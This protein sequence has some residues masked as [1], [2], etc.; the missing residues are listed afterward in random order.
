MWPKNSLS[1]CL[2]PCAQPRLGCPRTYFSGL[3][4]SV[5]R[6]SLLAYLSFASRWVIFFQV[7][8]STRPEQA[9]YPLST[10][11]LKL[12]LRFHREGPFDSTSL[13]DFCSVHGY[14]SLSL[15]FSWLSYVRKLKEDFL[16]WNSIARAHHRR[17]IVDDAYI[18]NLWLHLIFISFFFILLSSMIIASL[19]ACPPRIISGHWGTVSFCALLS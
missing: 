17:F 2:G 6:H 3:L 13:R 9:I 14:D 18:F 4:L 19:P 15:G 7:T 1:V 8:L 5:T 11:K 10:R 12:W 16:M